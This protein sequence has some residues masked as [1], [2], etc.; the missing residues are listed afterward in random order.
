MEELILELV[1]KY[2]VIATAIAGAISASTLAT[3]V[4]NLTP[5]PKDNTFVRKAYTVVEWLAG[6][7]T[8]KAKE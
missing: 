2:P 7:V 1:T 5:T 8:P 3:F 6:I 4:V